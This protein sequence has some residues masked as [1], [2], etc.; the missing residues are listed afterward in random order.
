MVMEKRAN[1]TN[2]NT[3]KTP[4]NRESFTH[5]LGDSIERLGKKISN[6]GAQRLGKAVYNTGDKIEHMND[7]RKGS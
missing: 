6:A 1:T 7:K 4:G 3:S 2:T 5:R